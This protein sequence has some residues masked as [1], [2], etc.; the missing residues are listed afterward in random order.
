MELA[1]G[2]TAG[3]ADTRFYLGFYFISFSFNY[4]QVDFK[5]DNKSFRI[6][7]YSAQLDPFFV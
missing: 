5:L 4:I 1:S 6:F 3:P 7:F 2:G